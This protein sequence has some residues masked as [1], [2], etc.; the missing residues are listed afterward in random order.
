MQRKKKLQKQEYKDIK[1][2]IRKQKSKETEYK[3]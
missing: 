2:E 3:G 1:Q